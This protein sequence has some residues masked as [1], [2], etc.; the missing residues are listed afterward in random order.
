M[1]RPKLISAQPARFQGGLVIGVKM[2]FGGGRAEVGADLT[3][4]PVSASMG[5]LD[6]DDPV[7]V[8]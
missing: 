6:E 4:D 1:V 5:G 8:D 7:H 3:M 2:I